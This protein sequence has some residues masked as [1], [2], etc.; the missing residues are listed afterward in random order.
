MLTFKAV[1]GILVY[2]TNTHDL[3][4]SSTSFSP[5]EELMYI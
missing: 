5:C 2:E 1:V 3:K 4:Q